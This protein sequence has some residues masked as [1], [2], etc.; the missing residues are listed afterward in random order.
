MFFLRQGTVERWGGH[1]VN[2]IHY[3]D[4][5]EFCLKVGSSNAT[6]LSLTV[7]L[8]TASPTLCHEREICSIMEIRIAVCASWTSL[9]QESLLSLELYYQPVCEK[10]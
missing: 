4:A 1:V 7:F 2:L 3:E 5:A 9:Q 6:P 8:E 10:S